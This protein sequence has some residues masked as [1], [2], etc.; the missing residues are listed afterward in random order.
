M[1]GFLQKILQSL[2]LCG[3]GESKVSQQ[4][5]S[6]EELGSSCQV[7]E[8]QNRIIDDLNYLV[9]ELKQQVN[10]KESEAQ[11]LQFR[12]VE[13]ES[14]NSELG[15]RCSSL[16]QEISE[17]RRNLTTH[18]VLDS[19][20]QH[21]LLFQEYRYIRDQD[22]KSM[23]NDIFRIKWESEPSPPQISRKQ[24]LAIL[25]SLLSREIFFQ[26]ISSYRKFGC[27]S[28]ESRI[29]IL[30]TVKALVF[31]YLDIAYT[32]QDLELN[33]ENLVFKGLQIVENISNATPR[34]DIWI[35]AEG[36]PFS[37]YRHEALLGCEEAGYIGLTVHPGYSATDPNSGKERIF[38]KAYVYTVASEDEWQTLMQRQWKVIEQQ[39]RSS[40]LNS[41]LL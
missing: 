9:S 14:K 18:P 13:L 31:R 1:C 8:S 35:E 5:D 33:L 28:E 12:I 10:Q 3:Q 22:L 40:S 38:E 11:Q 4:N 26:G 29:A 17:F 32:I 41:P 24:E 25:Q 37:L 34:G 16:L 30:N 36:T 39:L 20:P 2:K 15:E 7:D 6:V 27:F 21:H 19:H 23:S